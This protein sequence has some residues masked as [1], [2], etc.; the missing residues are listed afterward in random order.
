GA[1]DIGQMVQRLEA[2]VREGNPTAQGLM[3]LGRSYRVLGRDADAIGVLKQAAERDATPATLFAYGEALFRGGGDVD[4]AAATFE[5]VLAQAPRMPEALWYKSLTLVKRH[6]VDEA[7]VILRDLRGLVTD[8]Q[9]A[10]RAVGELLATLD[11]VGPA[12]TPRPQ[13][14]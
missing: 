11:R 4:E 3:M 8:N 14:N 1:P 5:R 10:T 6:R 13:A 7:R 2:R 12:G 9:E